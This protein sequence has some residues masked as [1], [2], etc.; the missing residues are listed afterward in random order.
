MTGDER[1]QEI[2]KKGIIKVLVCIVVGLI[3]VTIVNLM[4]R[5]FS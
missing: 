2:H 5:Y 3:V 4:G 1:D